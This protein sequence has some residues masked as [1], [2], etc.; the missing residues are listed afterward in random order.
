MS[1]PSNCGACGASCPTG[2]AC[3]GGACEQIQGNDNDQDGFTVAQ[4]DCDDNNPNINPGALDLPDEYF[5]DTNCDGI[6]GDELLAIFVSPSGVDSAG[7]GTKDNPVNTISYGIDVASNVGKTQ[8]IIAAGNY[9]ETVDL[10]SG[11]NLFGGFDANSWE[12]NYSTFKTYINGAHVA[13]KGDNISNV[14]MDGLY[15][16]SGN[17]TQYGESS[18]G[19]ILTNCINVD[20]SNCNINPGDGA[21]GRNGT[22][23]P[24]GNDGSNGGNGQNGCE[25]SAGFC[26]ICSQPNPGNGATSTCGRNGGNGGFPGL[27]GE[28]GGNGNTGAGGTPGGFGSLSE[29][30]C[31][32]NGSSGING[33]YGVNGTGG[34]L[35][36]LLDNGFYMPSNGANGTFGSHG[37][38]GSGGGGGHGGN[39]FCNSYGGAG[40]GGGAGG[41]RGLN[42]SAGTGGGAS[43][44][45]V[46]LNCGDLSEIQNCQINT[47]AV[48]NGGAGGAGGA[49]GIGGNGGLGGN[50]ED[51][52]S[53]GGAGGKG[54]D[55]GAGGD[56]GGGSGGSSIGILLSGSTATTVNN[57]FVIGAGGAGGSSTG[58]NGQSGISEN[59]YSL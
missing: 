8:I 13:V 32:A 10:K 33:T 1:D 56:G 34:S 17:A 36:S 47:S 9:I 52:S 39:S 58:N 24:S 29:A 50:G 57:N 11:I 26:S 12:R 5:I 53:C 28:N 3:V 42:G 18:Y 31:G 19:I 35:F 37:A 54:G 21:N 43:I 38:G 27:G 23:G 4:G 20:I 6:D 14:L 45:I 15:M 30:S 25:N 59:T 7:S 2:Y 46:L 16:Y 51:D 44:G 49:G 40:G 22:N 55:G 41:C 48:G